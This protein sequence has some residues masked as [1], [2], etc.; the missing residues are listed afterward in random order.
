MIVK[1]RWLSGLMLQIANLMYV[2]YVPWVRI[3]SSPIL[4]ILVNPFFDGI[5]SEK[6]T[7]G[8]IMLS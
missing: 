7:R 1:E 8:V 3:P 2:L 5:N 6:W 4:G